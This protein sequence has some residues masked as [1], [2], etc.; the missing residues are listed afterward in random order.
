MRTGSTGRVAAALGLSGLLLLMLGGTA[1]ARQD[2]RDRYTWSDGGSYQCDG[3]WVDWTAGG[4]GTLTIREG[5]RARAG[6]VFAHD[7]YQ[8]GATDVRR[9]DGASVHWSGRGNTREIQARHVAGSIYEVTSVDAGQVVVTDDD[10]DVLARSAG[11][12]REVF[13]IDTATDEIT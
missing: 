8:W 5:T 12:V 7:T 9:S 10:G 4:S 2:S 3:A 13:R 1:A 6:M 11:S